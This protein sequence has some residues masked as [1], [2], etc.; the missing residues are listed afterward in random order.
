MVV[1]RKLFTRDPPGGDQGRDTEVNPSLRS[2]E[3]LES[4]YEALIANQCRR[5][6]ISSNCV[7]VQVRQLGRANDGRMVYVGMLRL[8]KW[9]RFSGLRVLVGLPLLEAKL[10]RMVRN[11]WM[12]EVSHFSGLWLHSSEQL[13]QTAAMTELR[14]VMLQLTPFS[15]RPGG[16][17]SDDAA[18]SMPGALSGATPLGKVRP[19]TGGVPLSGMT[20]PGLDSGGPSSSRMDLG[21]SSRS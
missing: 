12:G 16:K 14:D 4:E 10:R 15:A 7:T 2:G 8:V 3:N 18:P 21:P 17:A 1:L 11:L 9:D 20:D 5:W 6:G 13:S 19:S